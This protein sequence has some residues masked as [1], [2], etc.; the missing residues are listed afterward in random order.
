MIRGQRVQ[1]VKVPPSDCINIGL[2]DTYCSLSF[3]CDNVPMDMQNVTL[4]STAIGLARPSGNSSWVCTFGSRP[5]LFHL[6]SM[7]FS[8]IYWYIFFSFSFFVSDYMSSLSNDKKLL[9]PLILLRRLHQFWSCATF[10]LI[11]H[12]NSLPRPPLVIPV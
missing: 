9:P 8:V 3:F 10:A 5:F 12:F 11:F 2:T 7:R 4:T 1:D 6:R